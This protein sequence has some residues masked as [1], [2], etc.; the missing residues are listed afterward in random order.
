MKNLKFY[1][2]I[3]PSP[4]RKTNKVKLPNATTTG[5]LQNITAEFALS[6]YHTLK[7]CPHSKN[8][9]AG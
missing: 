7:R 3:I 1:L 2:Q 8:Q 5:F 9:L 6:V 4:S